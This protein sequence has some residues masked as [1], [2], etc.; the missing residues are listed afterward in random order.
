MKMTSANATTGIDVDA[1][2]RRFGPMV[3]RRCKDLLGDD[4]AAADAMQETFVRVLRSRMT[5]RADYPSSLLYRI[6]TNVSLNMMRSARRRPVVKDNQLID[7]AAGRD[8]VEAQ[9]LDAALV[10]QI[11]HGVKESTRQAARIHYLECATLEETAERVG[12]SISG[13]RKRLDSL[14]RQSLVRAAR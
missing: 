10:E 2:Y 13:V 7:I 1:L 5:L 11:F 8:N 6:A 14:R 3:L 12:M 4:D 9:V